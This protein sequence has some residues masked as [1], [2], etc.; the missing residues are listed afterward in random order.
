MLHQVQ[1]VLVV[2]DHAIPVVTD[3]ILLVQEHVIQV[4]MEDV[5]SPVIVLVKI[6]VHTLALVVVLLRVVDQI[7]EVILEED[8]TPAV[9]LVV[10]VVEVAKILVIVA[11]KETV[12]IHVED[13]L[14]KEGV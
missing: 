13:L 3:A 12:K 4:A 10:I 11:A 5:M 2:T 14:A 9:P 1:G 8:Q 7:Q 6:S